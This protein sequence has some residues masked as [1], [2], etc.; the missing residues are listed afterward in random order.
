ML[1]E[2][3]AEKLFDGLADRPLPH[4]TVVIEDERIEAVVS[5]DPALP[6]GSA[7]L[8]TPVLA[9]GLIDMQINGAGDRLFNDAPTVETIEII[10]A[11][12]RLGGAAYVLPTFI[13]AKG[14]AFRQ[15]LEA[16]N[17]ARERRID[18]V[19]GL[20]LEGPFLS[21]KRPGIHDHSAIRPVE[22]DDLDALVVE[23]QSIRLITL[24]PEE[25]PDGVIKRLADTGWVVFAGHS[26]ATLNQMRRAADAGIS[27]ITHLFN[28]MSQITPREPGVVGSAFDDRRLFA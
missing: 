13:T 12:A 20:H 27:G 19:L 26:E 18:G 22:K 4:R 15:A 23:R 16:V 8:E 10:A 17:D 11:S 6:E 3:R 9:P 24:A 1:T 28:A 7:R 21:P 5:D 14:K 25:Q 2:I